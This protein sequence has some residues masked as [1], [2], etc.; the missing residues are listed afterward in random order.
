MI[1]EQFILTTLTLI[2]VHNASLH[3]PIDPCA[4]FCV[5][6]PTHAYIIQALNALPRTIGIAS[7][8]IK[9]ENIK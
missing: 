3:C 7:N 2:T 4:V 6:T 5:N 8:E 9:K 1:E